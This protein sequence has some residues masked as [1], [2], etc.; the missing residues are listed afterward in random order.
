MNNPFQNAPKSKKMMTVVGIYLAL[1]GSI[2]VSGSNSTLL[3][4]AAMD[5]GGQDIYA[6]A[7]SIAG[8]L[9]ISTM[10]LFGY[11]CAKNP[12]VK[13]TLCA[14]SMLVGAAV[15]FARAVAPS[16]IMIIIPSFFWG[17]VSAGL[18]VVGFSMIRDMFDLKQ[19]GIYLGMIGTMQSLGTLVGPLIAGA[20][21]DIFSWRIACH[22]IWPFLAVAGILILMGPKAT[23]EECKDMAS[24]MGTFDFAG[25]VS[26]VGF[27]T[28]MIL[29]LSLGTSFIPFGS[30]VSNLLIVAGVVS[31]VALILVIRKKKENAFVPAPVLKDGN[32]RS[33]AIC[34]LLL[35][36][37]SMA[38]FFFMPS[39]VLYAV[40]GSATQASLTT[41]LLAVPG[42][43]LSPILGRMIAKAGNARTV[44]TGGTIIR[45]GVTLCFLLF[46]FPDT[47]LMLI[48]G[49]MLLAGLYNCQQGVTF[50]TAPQVQIRPELRMMG[51][52]VIQVCQGLGSSIAMSVYTMI[53]AMFGVAQG[54]TVALG[55]AL[56]SAAIALFFGLTLKKLDTSE[57]KAA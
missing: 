10:P 50:S 55:L 5:I 35:N 37:S 28:S 1:I 36:F 53:I 19:A 40:G 21:I 3:P 12:A 29:V 44:M 57:E 8:I 11:L 18:Y 52:S 23:K 39:Y 42:L 16:M 56:A 47:P 14:A 54:M 32:V 4:A 20:L 51:N 22:A 25:A 38:V 48:Y 45:L 41:T 2:M 33:L 49:L 30:L 7:N 46:L 6:L 24:P 34:N 31:L 26:L 15:I 43:I 13:R 17:L 9:S 27:L